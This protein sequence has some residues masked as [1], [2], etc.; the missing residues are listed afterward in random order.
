MIKRLLI[1]FPIFVGSF[2]SSAQGS[3]KIFEGEEISLVGEWNL[4]MNSFL[5][6][7]EITRQHKAV[8]I[9]V[10]STWNDAIW[11]GE[12]VGPF[13][14]G[15]YFK[16]IIIDDNSTSPYL[17]IEVPE[18]SI[19]Y[20]LYANEK[21]IG[22]VGIPGENKSQT[23]PRIDFQVFDFEANPGDTVTFI[24]HVSNFSNKSGGLWYAPKLA[25]K[26][27]LFERTDLNRSLKLII[28]GC[29]LI[30]ALFQLSIFL[31]RRSEKSALYFFLICISLSMLLI[32]RSDLPIMDLFPNT[33]WIILKKTLYISIIL[34]GPV[35][36][37]FLHELF[38]KF[39]HKEIVVTMGIIALLLTT[40][41]LAASPRIT[42]SI[43]PYYHGY[44]VL[45]GIYLF[46]CLIRAAIANKFGAR[47]LLIGYIAAFLAVLHDILSSNYVIPGYSFDMMHVGI[48]FYILQLMFMLSGR[49]LF[50]LEGK[51]QLSVHLEKVNKEL[52]E[53]VDRRTKA[54][55]DK[56]KI[57][58][59]KNAELEKAMKEKDHL[60]AVVAHD[61][62][63]PLSSIQ[64]ISDLMKSDLKG[65]SAEFNEMIKKVTVDGRA[66]I[67]NLTELKVFEQ[68]DFEIKKSLLE[69]VDFFEQK[70]IAFGQLAEKKDIKLIATLDYTN[71]EV[72][73]DSNVLSRITDNLLSNAIKFTPKGGRVDLNISNKNDVLV[74]T[75]E[76]NGPGF[77]KIDKTKIFNK[78]QRLS[79]RPT[80]GESSAG[81]GLSIVKTLVD[82]LGGTISLESEEKQGSKFTVSIHLSEK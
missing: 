8:K 5:I 39:F 56:N 47:F 57:I 24:F 50:A 29:I 43:I 42:Y 30:G 13:G 20:R 37:L 36:A 65:Q 73:T 46:I 4:V 26:K 35:N 52:E 21:L 71:N 61:L 64:G 53:M 1:Y 79:A 16:T 62:K 28:I 32:T 11:N 34:I 58:E 9:N 25:F 3:P 18:V 33:S 66:M 69:L 72:L 31:K 12:K 19:A 70:K 6:Y 82:K 68:D 41:S 59:L 51:E 48:A 49:Y 80:A 27:D 17:A 76:D 22:Q 2:L 10:P 60:M 55:L 15:T 14:F 54:L 77:N 81:L 78:F 74:L 75:I 23:E 67:E 45:I 40:F 44:N 63:A 38:P 7:P